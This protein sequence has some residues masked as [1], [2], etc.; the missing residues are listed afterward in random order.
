MNERGLVASPHSLTSATVLNSYKLGNDY[1][2]K[3]KL[4]RN[5]S[6]IMAGAGLFCSNLKSLVASTRGTD[7]RSNLI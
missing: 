2:T 7:P 3:I 1:I 6:S 4:R 5:Y